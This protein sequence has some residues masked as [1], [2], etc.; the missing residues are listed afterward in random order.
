MFKIIFPVPFVHSFRIVD[1][2]SFS[3]SFG[4]DIFPIINRFFILLE[5]KGGR[6]VE[7]TDV[8]VTADLIFLEELEEILWI[9]GMAYDRM[10]P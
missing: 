5:F 8:K 7:L 4:I 9:A 10:G 3:F 2:Y 1:H 6:G